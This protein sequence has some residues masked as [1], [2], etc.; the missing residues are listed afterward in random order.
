MITAPGDDELAERRR[1]MVES[2]I[3]ARGIHDSRVLDAMATVPRHRFVNRR[4]ID[5][6]YGDYPID[7]GLGQTISQP[8]IVGYMTEALQLAPD[9]RVLEIGT[10]SGYQTAILA[11]LVR[12][13]YTI[14]IVPDLSRRAA[15]VL[16]SLGYHNVHLRAGDGYGGWPEAAPF[17]AAIVAAAAEHIPKP[18]VEQLVVGGRLVVPIGRWDQDLLVLTKTATGM[19]EE[20]RIPVRFV[21]FTRSS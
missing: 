10:G 8:Y 6:A 21:P 1:R 2:Q 5:L 13:V 18:I 16:E 11:A 9:H 14:E 20:T 4:E 15:A 3:R 17:D 12:E 19:R 7:I